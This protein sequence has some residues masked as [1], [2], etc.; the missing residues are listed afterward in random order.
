MAA[1][2]PAIPAPAV[3]PARCRQFLSEEGCPVNVSLDHPGKPVAAACDCGSDGSYVY[4]YAPLPEEEAGNEIWGVYEVERLI[5]P[6]F[7]RGFYYPEHD[8]DGSLMLDNQRGDRTLWLS[9]ETVEAICDFAAAGGI[10]IE[11]R[12]GRLSAVAA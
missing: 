9:A 10:P 11:T 7:L 12:R 1:S 4:V 3:P 6:D 8:D 2:S 5:H